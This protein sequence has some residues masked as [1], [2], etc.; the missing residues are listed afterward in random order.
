MMSKYDDESPLS[1]KD[2]IMHS[3]ERMTYTAPSLK[4]LGDLNQVTRSA[5]QANSDTSPFVDNTAF[6]PEELT[7]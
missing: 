1:K 3:Q 7:S 6:G 5:V 2:A 4:E